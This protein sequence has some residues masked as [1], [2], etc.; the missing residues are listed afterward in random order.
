VRLKTTDFLST[1]YN[2]HAATV[3]DVGA[4]GG[5]TLL[6]AL[7]E[8]ISVYMIEPDQ[9]SAEV[10]RNTDFSRFRKH[11]ID[12][13]ALS[14][15]KGTAE[16]HITQ[17]A[18]M[19]SLLEPERKEF[20]RGFGE[21]KNAKN[22][23][24]GMN[25][26]MKVEVETETLVGYQQ[27]IGVNFIDFLKLDTQGN[28]L[29]ILKSGEELL[30]S[31]RVGV[32]CT[33]VAYFPIYKGQSYFSE[34]DIFLRKCGFR[35]VE[36]RS[37]PDVL[38]RE[39]EFSAGNKLHERPKLA[40]VGDAWY[41]FNWDNG[42]SKVVEQRKRSA[43]VLA[44]E[45]Y[46]SEAKYLLE[47]ILNAEEQNDLFLHLSAPTRE[48]GFKHFLRRWTPPAVQQWRAKRRR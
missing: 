18:S 33:E 48:S 27:K 2:D 47:G 20:E 17:Q 5:F 39:D 4:R 24:A 10:L 26:A 40:P 7:H 38:E 43:S 35:F 19:S 6:P 31:G 15:S 25:V 22:W 9:A 29:E 13:L 37:Y 12:Q 45:G 8:F 1:L 23:R 44:C 42:D 11:T 16:L 32:I 36:C 14:S 34:I 28:E 3:L 21:M 30:K 41:V 46:F